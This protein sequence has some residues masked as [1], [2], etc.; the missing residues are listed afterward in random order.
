MEPKIKEGDLVIA[1][2]TIMP[3]SGEIVVCVNELTAM[4]KK[5]IVG[6]NGAVILHSLN[7]E[8][9]PPFVATLDGFKIEGVVKN[10]LQYE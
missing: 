8:K 4:I 2:K 5:Y 10:V 1:R 6:S 7:S 9:H 3:Q